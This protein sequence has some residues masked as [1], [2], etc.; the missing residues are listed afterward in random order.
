MSGVLTVDGN[1]PTPPYEQI[2]AQLAVAIGSGVFTMGERLPTVRQ[3][4]NDLGVA[5]GT[6]ARAYRELEQQQLIS[7][8]RGSGTRV[9]A[10]PRAR[11]DVLAEVASAYVGSCREVGASDAQIRAALDAALAR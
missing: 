8:R 5:P 4:A 3:L 7:S 10:P 11:D 9:S 6:V 1:D 2:R